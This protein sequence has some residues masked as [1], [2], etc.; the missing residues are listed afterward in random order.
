MNIVYR[1]NTAENVPSFVKY[2]AVLEKAGKYGS[3]INCKVS[4]ST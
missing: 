2:T 3:T 1:D 4:K